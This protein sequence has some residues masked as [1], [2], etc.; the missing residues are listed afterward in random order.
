VE[1]DSR[2]RQRQ[3]HLHLPGRGLDGIEHDQRAR[4][5]SPASRSRNAGVQ[6]QP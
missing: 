4:T 6:L 2:Y 5:A 1:Q 3:H